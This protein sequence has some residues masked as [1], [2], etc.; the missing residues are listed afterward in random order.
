MTWRRLRHI[1]RL[2]DKIHAFQFYRP[3][4]WKKGYRKAMVR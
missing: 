3:Y 4:W 1:V 2:Y